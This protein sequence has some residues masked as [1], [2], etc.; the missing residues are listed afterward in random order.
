[1]D[2]IKSFFIQITFLNSVVEVKEFLHYLKYSHPSRHGF[3]K[4][5]STTSSL[6]NISTLIANGF[7]QKQHP[8]RTFVA[9][10]DLSKAF[11]CNPIHLL[12]S[13]KFSSNIHHYIICTTLDQYTL[14]E[15]IMSLQVDSFN[16]PGL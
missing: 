4:L 12:F 16:L 5:H 6:L 3:K 14:R 13:K 9:S 7:N 8:S 10:L 11:D 2:R 1:M 15:N